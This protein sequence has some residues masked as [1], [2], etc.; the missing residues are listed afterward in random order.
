MLVR[1]GLANAIK[2]DDKSLLSNEGKFPVKRLAD[3][4]DSSISVA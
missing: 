3:E 1:G 4:H 2:H